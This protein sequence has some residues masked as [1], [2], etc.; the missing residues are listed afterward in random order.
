MSPLAFLLWVKLPAV[1]TAIAPPGLSPFTALFTVAI[2]CSISAIICISTCLPSYTVSS[3]KS[4][5]VLL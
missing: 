4:E 5:S 3:V 1:N 2:L